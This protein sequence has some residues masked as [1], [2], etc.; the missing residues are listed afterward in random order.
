MKRKF[1]RLIFLI[2]FILLTLLSCPNPMEDILALQI[3]D[4]TSPVVSLRSPVDGGV[5]TGRVVVEGSVTDEGGSVQSLAIAVPSAEVDETVEITADGTFSYT[6]STHGISETILITLTLTD[7]NGNTCVCT[8]TLFND[9][10]GPDIVISQPEDFSA[11]STVVSVSGYINDTP[12]SGTTEEVS[13]CSYNVPGTSIS[14]D[15]VPSTDGSFSFE[16][17]T[18]NSDGTDIIDG[19]VSIEVSAEDWN[20]NV[21]TE[22]VTIVKSE[23]GDF[24][25]VLITPA[26]GQVIIEWD[27]VLYAES[28]TIF[29]SKYGEEAVSVSS[30]YTWS[31]LENGEIYRFQIK[32]EIPEEKGEDAYSSTIDTMPLSERDFT[33]WI[34]EI[35]FGSITIEWWDNPN[36][37]EYIVERSLS[38][39][40]P[41]E[42]RRSLS[43]R[44]FTDEA[45]EQETE[46][47]YRVT[48]VGFEEITSEYVSAVPGYFGNE[49][50]TTVYTQ[51]SATN[52]AVDG[53]YAYVAAWNGGLRIVDISDPDNPV[54]VADIDSNTSTDAA[55]EVA[56]RGNYAF[57][58]DYNGGLTV[59]DIEDPT[60]PSWITQISTDGNP[61]GITLDG[62]YAYIGNG[63]SGLAVVDITDPENP[64]FKKNVATSGYTWGTTVY[65]SYAYSAVADAGVAVINISDPPNAS[66]VTEVATSD[67]AL[68]TA[69]VGSYLY[70]ADRAGGVRIMS[71]SNPA[72]PSE[73][74]S[75][76]LTRA[77]DLCVSGSYV[78][79][80]DYNDGLVI[81]S[82][83]NPA[84]PV[85]VT[86]VPSGGNPNGVAVF[87]KYTY[88]A[89][90]SGYLKV[91]KTVNPEN[92]VYICSEATAGGAKD[93][94]LSGDYAYVAD[95]NKEFSVIDI[96]DPEDPEKKTDYSWTSSGS[97]SGV[98]ISGPRVY[99]SASG[100]GLMVMDITDPENFVRT[101]HKYTSGYCMNTRA[102]GSSLYIADRHGGFSVADISDP[103][104]S[105][106]IT[107]LST[108]DD[109]NDIDI[110]GNYAFL[111]VGMSGIGVINIEDPGNP[112]SVVSSIPSTYAVEGITLSGNYAYLAANTTGIYVI[113]ISDPENPSNVTTFNTDG[114]A[115]NI[116]ICGDYAF[117]ADDS[118]GILIFSIS[119]P[120]DPVLV[121]TI[122][123]SDNAWSLALRGRYLYVADESAG[124]SVVRLTD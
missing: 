87:E 1:Y 56:I 123:T 34:R 23:T 85:T 58:A 76:A 66:L 51:G 42:I 15:I 92:P 59:I 21:T 97:P 91:V 55:S 96:S 28:Y 71:L 2:P 101:D 54:A 8:R 41:W 110:Q 27:P 67:Y 18:R 98:T 7:W 119:D 118:N 90:G 115:R 88:V 49:L 102:C 6:F 37:D 124:L 53:D 3:G 64:V 103:D 105:Q 12:G 106:L 62:N 121:T 81:L 78:Y 57:V 111:T 73:V 25:K 17:A 74:T 83:L 48:P 38:A 60:Q 86:T 75:V 94:G 14:G 32:A 26:N 30:P 39:D 61:R 40:G 122:P 117:V 13:A 46:Y 116:T 65:G 16:F 80:A 31:G 79:V 77:Y 52:V 63:D 89:S 44:Y 108:S 36:V 82:T 107:S 112:V 99:L 120:E 10:T 9:E 43:A 70:V 35:G 100:A 47:Y 93:V 19:P 11:Y 114:K 29:E 95:Y 50:V 22:E 4:E 109:T 84:S 20:G 69:V 45:V 104:N 72:A 113:D 33:P 24:S 5:F 68:N